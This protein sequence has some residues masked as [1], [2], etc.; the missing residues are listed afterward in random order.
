MKKIFLVS[1]VSLLLFGCEAMDTTPGQVS[2][3]YGFWENQYGPVESLGSGMYGIKGRDVATA[4]KGANRHCSNG[5][6]V[7]TVSEPENSYP[8]V[9]FT[10]K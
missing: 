1:V 2:G 10:C 7:S 8:Q 9:I 5:A 3:E 6:D 4:I